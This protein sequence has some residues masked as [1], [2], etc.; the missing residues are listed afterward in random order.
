MIGGL[1]GQVAN[2]APSRGDAPPRL[3]QAP[4]QPQ[5]NHDRDHDRDRQQPGHHEVESRG[6]D[7]GHPGGHMDEGPRGRP[8]VVRP[9][10]RPH[11]PG[12]II[13][14]PPCKRGGPGITPC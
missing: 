6:N 1:S 11:P 9:P 12:P 2:A 7:H 4:I 13:V 8:P 3:A 10:I 5:A 14:V